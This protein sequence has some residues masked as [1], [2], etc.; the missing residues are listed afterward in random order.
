MNPLIRKLKS[1]A[2]LENCVEIQS[3][4]WGLREEETVSAGILATCLKHNAL[5]LGSFH[6][7]KLTGFCFS[8]PSRWKG[9]PAHHSHMLAVLPGFR[10]QGTGFALKKAQ[11]D[12]LKKSV[13]W[14]TWTFDP[15]ESRN[16]AL[17]LKL[18]VSIN[19]YLRELYGDGENCSLHQ[20][21]GTDRFV[22]EWPTSRPRQPR[23]E[24]PASFLSPQNS[25]LATEWDEAGFYRPAGI[26]LARQGRTL[27]MEIPE[28]I[29]RIKEADL[30]C[31]KAWRKMTRGAAEHYFAKGYTIREFHSFTDART[32][33]RRSFY[34]LQ[35][36][37]PKK[38][39]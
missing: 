10:D 34:L 20:G 18:G 9:E 6:Q 7:E 5:L 28:N 30:L 4:V 15:L 22:A 24:H 11:F 29:Q 39:P 17:N 27:L 16:A 36:P 32:G 37:T 12:A 3:L 14:I 19:T 33:T 26:D 21:L 25:V 8:I 31:V 38:N 1:K 35:S 2:E 23:A 13:N